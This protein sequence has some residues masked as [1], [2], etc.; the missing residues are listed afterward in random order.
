MMRKGEVYLRSVGSCL[1]ACDAQ[2]LNAAPDGAGSPA[3][4]SAGSSSRLIRLHTTETLQ[5]NF[6]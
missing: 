3:T 6:K 5:S 2:G 1:H 4:S